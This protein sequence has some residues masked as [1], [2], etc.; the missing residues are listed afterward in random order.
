[1]SSALSNLNISEASWPVLIKFYVNITGVG[2]RLHKV[3]GQTGS[4]TLVSMATESSYGLIMGKMMSP[5]FYAP[6]FE[7]GAYWFRGL[8]LC[9]LI[10]D[11]V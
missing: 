6:S 7:D 9:Q 11:D 1:M 4:K 2:E 5:P 3:L 10:G 8:K